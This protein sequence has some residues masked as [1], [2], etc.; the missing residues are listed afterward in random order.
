MNNF[1]DYKISLGMVLCLL[2]VSLGNF[3]RVL[4][5]INLV[6]PFMII[7]IFCLMDFGNL[8]RFKFPNMSTDIFL[9]LISQLII[10]LYMILGNSKEM[11]ITKEVFVYY[12]VILILAIASLQKKYPDKLISVFYI[13]ALVNVV[14]A[15]YLFFNGFSGMLTGNV[16]KEYLNS[17]EE[18]GKAM[19]FLYPSAG[20]YHT[21]A[22]LALLKEYNF[23]SKF[24]RTLIISFLFIDFILIISSGKRTVVLVFVLYILYYLWNEHKFSS[25]KNFLKLIPLVLVIFLIIKVALPHIPFVTDFVNDFFDNLQKGIDT[26]FG[27]DH[28]NYDESAAQRVAIRRK[29]ALIYDSDFSFINY[30]FGKGYMIM[31]MDQ[32][33]LQ[34]VFD[35]G[36]V[37]VFVYIYNVIIV[38]V[39]H[40]VKK[41]NDSVYFLFKLGCINIVLT[42][43]TAGTPYGYQM[44]CPVL[45]MLYAYHN[46]K[47]YFYAQK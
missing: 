37:G 17:L 30:I 19:V 31:Y 5:G 35:M 27:L 28:S 36:L 12:S 8:M 1:K 10:V 4:T 40:L 20:V 16:D 23:K 39:K 21:M 38:S 45:F 26:L 22:T 7:S 46:Q 9:L 32:P 2:G 47:K 6:I 33:L 3:I 41:T 29:A 34:S 11:N 43:F 15:L 14:M 25:L 18:T 44:Y 24:L 42:C 13:F